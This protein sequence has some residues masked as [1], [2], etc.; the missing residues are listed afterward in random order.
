MLMSFSYGV[1][2]MVSLMSD[3]RVSFL[4]WFIAVA[5][6]VATFLII[7]EIRLKRKR[8]RDLLRKKERT[9]IDRMREFLGGDASPKE[10]LDVIGKTAKDFFISEYKFENALDYGDF[11]N[12]F[13]KMGLREEADFCD[14]IFDAYYSNHDL[15]EASIFRLSE[16]LSNIYKNKKSPVRVIRAPSIGDRIDI[17]LDSFV[18]YISSK[19][20]RYVKIKSERLE[21][22]ERIA[23]RQEHEL[24]SWV[25]SAIQLGYDKM[26]IISLLNDG[27]R[28][29][30]DIKKVLKVYDKELSRNK[31]N[32]EVGGL[33][34]LKEGVAKRI[35]QNE[36]DRLEEAG[37]YTR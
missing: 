13:E 16:M 23:A 7:I 6:V 34:S 21:R 30:K 19:V 2:R 27:S 28:K 14:K 10:K 4:I 22:D 3:A 31:P 1:W 35:V 33:Y 11:K 12:E 32:K 5:I 29:K 25:R 36:K 15:D 37:G 20:N 18:G 26:N 24:L 17:F 8:D 9:P